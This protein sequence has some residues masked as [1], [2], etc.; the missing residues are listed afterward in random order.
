VPHINKSSL[1]RAAIT[2]AH[3]IPPNHPRLQDYTLTSLVL[4]QVIKAL[5][6]GIAC[7]ACMMQNCC[8]TVKS[9]T[10][11][12]LF[13]LFTLQ[14]P[15]VQ[16]WGESPCKAA[17]CNGLTGEHLDHPQWS[18]VRHWDCNRTSRLSGHA[19]VNLKKIN[20]AT[21]SAGCDGYSSIGYSGPHFKAN[22]HVL[23]NRSPRLPLLSW[24]ESTRQ[25]E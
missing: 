1:C 23:P 19:S 6:Q 2:A 20:K 22:N 18:W 8:K 25:P 12:S 17:F 11:K 14:W 10:P 21:F 7:I 3:C 16:I 5:L 4:G 15:S 13:S 9:W 24:F